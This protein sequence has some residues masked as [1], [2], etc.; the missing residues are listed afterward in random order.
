MKCDPIQSEKN[1][2]LKA[3]REFT[4]HRDDLPT[5]YAIT[6]TVKKLVQKADLTR[7]SY[8]LKWVPNLHWIII[9]DAE[10]KSDMVERLLK[11]SKISYTHLNFRT[12]DE[13]QI[14]PG[15]KWYSKPRGVLQRN[16]GLKWIRENLN[17]H[18][19]KG[20][21]YFVDDDNTYDL[22]LFEE[23]LNKD[24]FQYLLS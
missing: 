11:K 10:E 4:N 21:V 15:E 3:E 22:E 23:V 19:N 1:S 14:H 8:T 20:T 9:E 2:F 18:I 24:T 5:I 7:L 12:P 17:P 6:P 16:L 13:H